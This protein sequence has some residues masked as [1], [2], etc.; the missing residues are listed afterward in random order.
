MSGKVSKKKGNSLPPVPV[1]D[2]SASGEGYQTVVN[3]GTMGV[4]GTSAATPAFAAMISL[5]N[6]ARAKQGKPSMGFL[7]PFLY[8][9]PQA[10]TDITQ[11]NNKI[12]RGGRHVQNGFETTK[13]WDPVTGMGTPL[14]GELLSAAMKH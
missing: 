2:V 11:G 13:G 6:E 14:F 4:G 10:F 8:K 1:P 7:N 12:D 9:H 3:G 5:V